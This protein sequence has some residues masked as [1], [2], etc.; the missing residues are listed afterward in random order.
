MPS[1]KLLFVIMLGHYTLTYLWDYIFLFHWIGNLGNFLHPLRCKMFYG[2]GLEHWSRCVPPL[3]TFFQ[4]IKQ[5]YKIGFGLE[6]VYALCWGGECVR[7]PEGGLET[8][9]NMDKMARSLRGCRCRKG[10]KHMGFNIWDVQFSGQ[11]EG[12]HTHKPTHA[13]RHTRS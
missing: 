8:I 5:A 10:N 1:D 4:G 11:P 7:C 3:C 13:P 12:P 9:C 6:H 2:I